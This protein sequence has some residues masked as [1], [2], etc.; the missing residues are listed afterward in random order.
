MFCESVN[1]LTK[2]TLLMKT[3]PVRIGEVRRGLNGL[4]R[5]PSPGVTLYYSFNVFGDWDT[6]IW[7][8]A[9][10]HDQAMDFVQNKIAKIPGIVEIHTLPTTILKEYVQGW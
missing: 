8:H 5:T 3:D 4:S 1:N 9:D 10:K 2:Y 7:F 6:C